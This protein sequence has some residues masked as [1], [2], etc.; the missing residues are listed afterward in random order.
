[1]RT[2]D[3]LVHLLDRRLRLLHPYMPYITE[4]IWRFLP[5]HDRPLIIAPWPQADERFI[6]PAAEAEFGILMDLV[7]GLRDVRAEYRVTPSTQLT[8]VVD[9]GSHRDLI[10]QHQYVFA[11]LCHVREVPLNHGGAAP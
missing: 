6:D 9:A 3:V 11:R 7:R 8:A 2:L 10:A 5:A 1:E 4:E